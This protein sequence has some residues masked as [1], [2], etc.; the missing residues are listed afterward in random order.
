MSTRAKQ[1]GLVGIGLA[2]A[3]VMIW[4]GLWQMQVFVDKGNRSVE[5]RAS[6]PAVPLAEHL[7]SDGQVGDIYGKQVTFTG[8]YLPGQEVVIPTGAGQRV[9]TALQLDD[10]RVLAVVRGLTTGGAGAPPTGVVTQTGLFLPGEGD[11]KGV[12]PDGSLRT[13]RM[14]LLAQVWPQQLV[15]GFVT[16]NAAESAAQGLAQ[17]PVQLPGG[18][19]SVQNSGYALQWWVFAAFALGMSIKF[20]HTLGVQQRRREEDKLTASAETLPST[21]TEEDHTV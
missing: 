21:T 8:T 15:A 2:L 9:L 19:G 10:G 6:Q 16:L 3:A 12:V 7:G 1:V 18:E 14:P 20:S 5:D 13:V 11:P 17:A 4:L